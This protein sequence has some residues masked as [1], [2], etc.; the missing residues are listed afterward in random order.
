M[1][2]PAR[3]TPLLLFREKVLRPR[4]AETTALGAAFA[5]GLAVGIWS[6]CEELSRTWVV[7][8][9]YEST[10]KADTREMVTRSRTGRAGRSNLLASYVFVQQVELCFDIT[11]RVNPFDEKVSYMHTRVRGLSRAC[12]PL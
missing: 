5:A 11:M 6:D 8:D 9:S 12:F 7:Q 3:P 10:M 4:V 1:S 2:A